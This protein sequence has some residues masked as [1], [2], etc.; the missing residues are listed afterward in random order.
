MW[1]GNPVS[2]VASVGVGVLA[3]LMIRAVT[4]RS[5]LRAPLGGQARGA[6]DANV[7]VT[8]CGTVLSEAPSRGLLDF[9]SLWAVAGPAVVEARCERVPAGSGGPR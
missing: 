2:L 8:V 1:V 4:R 6:T 3:A 7:R 9:S 5:P